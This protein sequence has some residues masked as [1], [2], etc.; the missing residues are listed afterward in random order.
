MTDYIVFTRIFKTPNSSA[1]KPHK[2]WFVRSSLKIFQSITPLVFLSVVAM[3]IGFLLQTAS[4]AEQNNQP[5]VGALEE[6]RN[7][8]EAGNTEAQYKL[9]KMYEEGLGVPQDSKLAAKWYLK[10]AEK[11]NGQ[12][13]YKMGTMYTRGRGVPR[14]IMEAA[15][16][17]AK[18]GRQG[19]EPAKRQIQE[20]GGNLKDQLLKD[21]LGM[22]QRKT[23]G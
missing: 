18:A 12:A 17:F 3:T 6:C 21:P 10:A 7:L 16:W 9:G 23:G 13:Q 19:Y 1:N 2:I 8:A 22:F 11:G 5:A 4:A 15:K 14:D 20:T